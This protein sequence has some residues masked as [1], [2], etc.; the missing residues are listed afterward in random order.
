MPMEAASTSLRAIRFATPD[1]WVSYQCWPRSGRSTISE[2]GKILNIFIIT[3]MFFQ[4]FLLTK[5]F[6][7]IDFICNADVSYAK[8]LNKD[9]HSNLAMFS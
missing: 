1:F 4:V 7:S 6:A 5:K 2:I 3:T 9:D 8:D